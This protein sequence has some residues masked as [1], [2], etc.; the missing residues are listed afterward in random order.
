[1]FAV[2]EWYGTWVERMQNAC[3]QLAVGW[4]DSATAHAVVHLCSTVTA[5]ATCCMVLYGASDVR[6]W[7]GFEHVTWNFTF[8]KASC[9]VFLE[10]RLEYESSREQ[11]VT[12]LTG[13]LS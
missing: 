9:V 4:K 13:C 5:H 8:L 3:K 12:Q 7:L 10:S 2:Q 6:V 1:M 11:L